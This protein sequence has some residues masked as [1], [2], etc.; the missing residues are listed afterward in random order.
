MRGSF[1]ALPKVHLDTREAQG[2]PRGVLGA[3]IRRIPNTLILVTFYLVL[4]AGFGLELQPSA[5]DAYGAH[6]AVDVQP[7]M[8]DSKSRLWGPP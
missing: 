3:K 5:A 6:V 2:D 1:I 4:H 8:S 7:T